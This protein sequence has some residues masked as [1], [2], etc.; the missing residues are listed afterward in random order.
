L[1]LDQGW[2]KFGSR[3]NFLDPQHCCI[4]TVFCRPRKRPGD[5][6]SSLK[7]GQPNFKFS[8]VPVPYCKLSCC[9]LPE[10]DLWINCIYLVEQAGLVDEERQCWVCFASDEDDPTAAWVHPCRWST[11]PVPYWTPS[12]FSCGIWACRRL[13]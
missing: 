8:Y 6:G 7:G 1:T 3:I 11:V 9:Q 4:H 10:V 12:T 13:F 5:L 2:K